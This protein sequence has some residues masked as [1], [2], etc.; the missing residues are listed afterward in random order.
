MRHTELRTRMDAA[1]G[2]G[3]ARTWADLYVMSE[4]GGRT[5][6]QALDAGESPKRVWIA[7][8]RELGLPL[9]DR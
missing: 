8:W 5:V 1:L 4:L 9:A 6:E 7:V 2:S 3:Y